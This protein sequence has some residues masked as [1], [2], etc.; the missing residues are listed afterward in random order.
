MDRLEEDKSE[1][2]PTKSPKNIEDDYADLKN[3]RKTDPIFVMGYPEACQFVVVGGS[4]CNE[5][6]TPQT[7]ENKDDSKLIL[8]QASIAEGNSGSPVFNKQGK[9]IGFVTRKYILNPNIALVIPFYSIS[10][11]LQRILEEIDTPSLPEEVDIVMLNND[12]ENDKCFGLNSF[13]E[14]TNSINLN[15]K[16]TLLNPN[17]T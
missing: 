13:Q 1:K 3:I 12:T 4:I 9:L 8:I 15:L 7:S 11:Y 5:N 16:N 6:Y 2:S 10:G 17:I 14:V